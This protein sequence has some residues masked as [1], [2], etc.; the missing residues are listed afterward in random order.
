MYK[1][2]LKN[3]RLIV[4]LFSIGYFKPAP[5]TIGSFI[6]LI[7]LFLISNFVSYGIFILLFFILIII[8]NYSIKLYIEN[9]KEKDAPE[10]IIDEFLGC[11]LIVIFF[12]YFDKIN[13]ILL[14]F[15]SFIVF[16]FFD[17][18][19]IYPI[20]LIDKNFKNPLGIIL[21]DL[22]AALYTIITLFIFSI[23]VY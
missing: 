21:D 9:I 12:P 7:I 16:R 1:F 3:N 17:I 22:I 15:I 5:G 19:K 11:Y 6:S 20:N 18:L 8:S 2:F 4:T 14:Y 10:I 23:Y 13:I